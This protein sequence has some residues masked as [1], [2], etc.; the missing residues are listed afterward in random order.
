MQRADAALTEHEPEDYWTGHADSAVEEYE[1][2][3]LKHGEA[4]GASVASYERGNNVHHR[5]FNC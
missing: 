5:T 3:P 1:N 4:Y 2:G